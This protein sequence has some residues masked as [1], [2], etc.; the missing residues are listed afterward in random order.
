MTQFKIESKFLFIFKI[1]FEILIDLAKNDYKS[2]NHVQ[3]PGLG[4]F[5]GKIITLLNLYLVLLLEW[6]IVPPTSFVNGPFSMILF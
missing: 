5:L 4:H 3:L 2:S 6:S 1:F